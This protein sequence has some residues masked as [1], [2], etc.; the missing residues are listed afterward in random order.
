MS[1][2]ARSPIRLQM[3]TYEESWK[4][5]HEDVRGCWEIEDTIRIG[6]ATFDVIDG[7]ER[8][9]RDRVLRGIEPETDKANTFYLETYSSWLEVT[10][11]VLERVALVERSYEVDGAERLR[12]AEVD[13]SRIVKAWQPPRLTRLV[14]MREITLP[15]EA[16]TELDKILDEAKSRPRPIPSGPV[17]RGMPLADFLTSEKGS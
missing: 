13:A 12:V 11:H 2:K 17:P 5:E 9:W 10:A 7:A 1:H 4:G 6:I 8:S 16:A 14:A 3:T 15:P